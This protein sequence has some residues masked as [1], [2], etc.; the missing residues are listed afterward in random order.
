MSWRGRDINML[1]ATEKA[2]FM[3]NAF[4]A[5]ARRKD[6]IKNYIAKVKANRQPIAPVVAEGNCAAAKSE[7]AD[8]T[9]GLSMKTSIS[10]N[11]IFR[12]AS[13]LWTEAVLTNGSEGVIHYIIYDSQKRPL[14]LPVAI[15][16][17]FNC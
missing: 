8:Q 12:L 3:D 4:L 14:S 7:S 9:A 1:P 11:T 5:W 6:M 17:A 2:I 13:N 10:K 16:A 15:I